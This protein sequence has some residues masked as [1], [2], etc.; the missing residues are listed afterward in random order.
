MYKV[1]RILVYLPKA[2]TQRSYYP[3]NQVDSG[4]TIWLV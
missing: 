2:V 1:Q 3:D 4:L